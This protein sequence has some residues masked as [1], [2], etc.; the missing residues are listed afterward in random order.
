ML[1]LTPDLLLCA[2]ASGLFPMADD[3]HDPTIHWI[4]PRRR[5]VLPLDAFHEPRSLR[6]EIRRRPFEINVDRAVGAVRGASAAPPP[7]RPRTGGNDDGV[8]V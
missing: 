3:R 4:E 6:R 1:A 5:G 2:Y 7:E 8:A